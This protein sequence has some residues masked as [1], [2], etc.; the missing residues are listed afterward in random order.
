MKIDIFT[1][2]PLGVSDRASVDGKLNFS[3]KNLNID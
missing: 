1:I 2:L 3:E